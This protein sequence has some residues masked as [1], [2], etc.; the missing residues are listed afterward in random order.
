RHKSPSQFIHTNAGQL[1]DSG[2]SVYSLNVNPSGVNPNTIVEDP[3]SGTDP[4]SPNPVS[5]L[6]D[7]LRNLPSLEA[8]YKHFNSQ[9]LTTL[10]KYIPNIIC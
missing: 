6:H 10:T 9:E 5:M 3:L 7:L 4:A 8:N 1:V 2:T